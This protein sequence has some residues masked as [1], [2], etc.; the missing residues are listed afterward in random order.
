M[1]PLVEI[2]L[3]SYLQ[4]LTCLLRAQLDQRFLSTMLQQDSVVRKGT[5]I[6][7]LINRCLQQRK[8]GIIDE[9]D[10]D[11]ERCKRQ[12]PYSKFKNEKDH[13]VKVFEHLMLRGQVC[14]AVCFITNRVD[15]GGVC[16]WM[17]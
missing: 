15:G 4:K 16:L 12:L 6:H 8:E 5:D 7:R 3:F 17:I 2:L 1:A 14:Y 11:C 9:L 13:C 10:T